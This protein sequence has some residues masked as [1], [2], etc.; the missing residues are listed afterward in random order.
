[1]K[2]VKC[3]DGSL[4]AAKI[5][6]RSADWA[7]E[8]KILNELTS[9][10]TLKVLDHGENTMLASPV[11]G[12]LTSADA[13]AELCDASFSYIIIELVENGELYDYLELCG[14]LGETI[15]RSYFRE[16]IA[17]LEYIHSK[18]ISHRDIKPQNLMLTSDYGIKLVDFGLSS[19]GKEVDYSDPCGTPG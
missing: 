14:P 4:A 3:P 7:H 2:L 16:I 13:C 12:A 18:G 11:E 1:M 10:W 8:F 15:S 19:F 5:F 17:A 9:Q 6:K